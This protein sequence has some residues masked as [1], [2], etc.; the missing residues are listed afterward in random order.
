MQ[1][2]RYTISIFKTVFF[3]VKNNKLERTFRCVDAYVD[4]SFIVTEFK[5][6][7]ES[8]PVH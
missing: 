7:M 1:N 2:V 3:I 4:G 5:E 8:S 6:R